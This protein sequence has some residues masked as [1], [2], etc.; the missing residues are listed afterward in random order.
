MSAP[1]TRLSEYP[2]AQ[3]H[4]RPVPC[5]SSEIAPR[6]RRRFELKVPVWYARVTKLEGDNPEDLPI[7][8]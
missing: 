7:C 4:P 2:T 5:R 3:R 8:R 1:K 6:G